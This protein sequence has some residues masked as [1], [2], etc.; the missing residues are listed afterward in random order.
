MFI[1]LIVVVRFFLE[2]MQTV[3]D[4]SQASDAPALAFFPTSVVNASVPH[5]PA[6]SS[7]HTA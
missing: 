3:E 6:V 7:N 4:R 2:T 1:Y 5:P